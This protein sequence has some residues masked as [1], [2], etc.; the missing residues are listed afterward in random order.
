M[1]KEQI[2]LYHIDCPIVAVT[3]IDEDVNHYELYRSI[4]EGLFRCGYSVVG[5]CNVEN[6]I[7]GISNVN[8]PKALSENLGTHSKV[9]SVNH[10]FAQMIKKYSP[11]IIVMFVSEPIMERNAWTYNS[12]GEM[13]HVLCAAMD[14]DISIAMIP[15]H[16]VNEAFVNE[17]E[18]IYKYRFSTELFRIFMSTVGFF[19]H[20]EEDSVDKYDIPENF[21]LTQ[22]VRNNIG[23][24]V[25]RKGDNSIV[26]DI[27]AYLQEE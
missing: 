18:M 15:P 19:W 25:F 14:V 21:I 4:C 5:V 9:V 13:M 7:D 6:K 17:L 24:D 27:I 2:G 3:S 22:Y 26:S 12:C 11:D 1:R 16:E 8:F 20:I 23:I 10:E